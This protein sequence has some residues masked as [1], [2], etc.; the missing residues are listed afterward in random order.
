MR[1]SLNLTHCTLNT[2]PP[3]S[4][5]RARSAGRRRVWAIAKAKSRR[6]VS[7]G[8]CNNYIADVDPAPRQVHMPTYIRSATHSC[9]FSTLSPRCGYVLVELHPPA[10]S[11][12]TTSQSTIEALMWSLTRFS[13]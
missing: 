1:P 11:H 3:A 12:L 4:S 13:S 7:A 6:L 9:D 10:L 2:A 8:N 5:T